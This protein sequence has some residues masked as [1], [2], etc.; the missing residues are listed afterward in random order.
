[1]YFVDR[2]QRLKLN[3]CLSFY[4]LNKIYRFHVILLLVIFSCS[5]Q[6]QN[7]NAQWRKIPV[8]INGSNMGI[9]RSIFFFDRCHGIAYASSHFLYTEDGFTWHQSTPNVK[10]G[11]YCHLISYDGQTVFAGV[12]IDAFQNGEVL[13]SLDSGRTWI[14]VK[15]FPPSI[16]WDI[17]K[18]SA[19]DFM[20]ERGMTFAQFD[21]NHV[22]KVSDGVV[23]MLPL[24]SFNGGL[25]WNPSKGLWRTGHWVAGW[26]ICADTLHHMF[27]TLNES[28]IGSGQMIRSLD[29]GKIW[30]LIPSQP[31]GNAWTD[32]LVCSHGNTYIQTDSGVFRTND[33]AS[34]WQNLGREPAFVVGDGNH[35]C[36]FGCHGLAF[37]CTDTS[38]NIWMTGE[39]DADPHLITPINLKVFPLACLSIDTEIIITNPYCGSICIDSI[40]IDGNNFV[41]K[42]SSKSILCIEPGNSDTVKLSLNANNLLQHDTGF[43]HIATLTCNPLIT[44]TLLSQSIDPKS[45]SITIQ[46]QNSAKA[47]DLIDYNLIASDTIPADVNSIDLILEVSD[48]VLIFL[49]TDPHIHL[50]SASGLSNGLE[51]ISLHIEPLSNHSGIIATIHFQVVLSQISLSP[52]QINNVVLNSIFHRPQNCIA[53]LSLDSI[54]FTR[55]VDCGDSTLLKFMY[56]NSF[57]QLKIFPNPASDKIFIFSSG[58][59]LKI[60]LIDML[61]RVALHYSGSAC[62]NIMDVTN[63]PAGSYILRTRSVGNELSKIINV[64]H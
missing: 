15:V 41:I 57:P 38:G 1:M 62:E 50:I 44:I 42:D 6:V 49:K 4:M 8:E 34:T 56:M 12:D 59:L 47:G 24:F 63:I 51:Q 29:S 58:G 46:G 33:G 16:L 64:I 32:E 53:S 11:A 36:A 7:G 17:Y 21:N 14:N 23:E 10:L 37:A 30:D 43:L 5:F 28:E 55:T 9:P 19:G 35:L 48:S 18:N 26:G 25:S 60:E 61:G 40:W 39:D 54:L 22:I 52:I 3:I 27:F 20:T 31:P 45:I 13:E 2:L